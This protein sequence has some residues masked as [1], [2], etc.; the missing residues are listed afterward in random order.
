M[1]LLMVE[2]A[3]EPIILTFDVFMCNVEA[4]FNDWHFRGHGT[5]DQPLHNMP[6]PSLCQVKY[7]HDLFVWL[8]AIGYCSD[9]LSNCE[10]DIESGLPY[11]IVRD[12]M[13]HRL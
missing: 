10:C 7:T 3:L 6:L 12:V 8:D 4:L 13:H 1:P 11:A 2:D 9:T 5:I